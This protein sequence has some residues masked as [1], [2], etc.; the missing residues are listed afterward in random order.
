MRMTRKKKIRLTLGTERPWK[1]FVPAGEL[2]TTRPI[3]QMATN[4]DFAIE[5]GARS[6]S[7][8]VFPHLQVTLRWEL[9]DGSRHEAA[10]AWR[11]VQVISAR[12]VWI[13]ATKPLHH[14]RS[15]Q[16]ADGFI[17]YLA[18]QTDS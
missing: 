1:I 8:P 7:E 9:Q 3:A 17:T 12:T 5:Y 4:T 11:T 6:R 15:A 10:L 14:I 2:N 18:G 13:Q 16:R